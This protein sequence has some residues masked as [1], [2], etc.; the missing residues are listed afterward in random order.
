MN[1]IFNKRA[2]LSLALV[3]SIFLTSCSS[4]DDGDEFGNWVE[5]SSFN[6]T[7][8]SG[9][10]S[11]TIGDKGYV[12]GGLDD[13]DYLNETWEYDVTGNFWVEKNLIENVDKEMVPQFPGVER[14]LAVGFTINGKG[15]YGTGF[16]GTNRLKDFYEYDPATDAWTQIAD[17]PGT[18]RYNAVGFSVGNYGYVGT[19]YDGS[20]QKDFYRYNP[21]TDSWEEYNGFSGEKRQQAYTFKIDDVVYLG[22][23][24]RNGA[25]EEDFYSFDGTSF[26]QLEDLDDDDDDSDDFEI[27]VANGSAFSINGKGYLA[28]G[29]SGAVTTNAWEY[30]PTTDTWDEL[31][32]FEG[33]SRQGAPAFT[34]TSG[35]ESYE[36]DDRA[37]VLLGRTSNFYFDDVWEFK[38][39]ELENEDD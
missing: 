8:R 19:G 4:D 24:I 15:Y 7:S 9:S 6:G 3:S 32:A 14:S 30:D 29:L 31:P 10:V 18:A 33:S 5:M 21:S 20:E 25:Y 36:G 26:T 38:P 12:V 27:L 39:E 23:G 34:F 37:F 16:D 2:L 35:V 17:F 22:G 28:T 1:Y 13:D 11:F